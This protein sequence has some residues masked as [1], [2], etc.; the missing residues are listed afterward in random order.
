MAKSSLIGPVGMLSGGIIGAGIFSLPYV[1]HQAG[2]LVGLSLVA[3]AT[4]A[5]CVIHL[6]YADIIIGTTGQH[7]FVGYVGRYLGKNA[8]YVAILMSVVEMVLVLTI[9]L[10]LSVSFSRLLVPQ[11][12]P[13]V[14]LAVFWIIGSTSIF[15]DQKKFTRAEVVASFGIIATVAILFF[16]GIP[17]FSRLTG[18]AL[19]GGGNILLPLSAILFA[20]SG[21]VAIPSLVKL[22]RGGPTGSIKRAVVWGTVVPGIVYAFFILSILALSGGVSEDS[23]SGVVGL[24]PTWLLL[25]VGILGLLALWSSYMLVGLD[26]S[27]TLKYDL[28]LPVWLRACIVVVVPLVL[29]VLGFTNFIQLVGFVGGIFLAFEGIFI[30]LAWSVA[31]RRRSLGGLITVSWPTMLFLWIVFCG[32]LAGLLFS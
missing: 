7:R 16:A 26:V 25:I 19:V 20:L 11:I 31:R 32:A 30:S 17:Q 13:V 3:V 28:N 24:I 2:L 18:Q 22:L 29:Y 23:V 15:M 6:M 10:I 5:Y 1:T 27:E 14:A 21:R 4:V 12:T 9:Y 8:S